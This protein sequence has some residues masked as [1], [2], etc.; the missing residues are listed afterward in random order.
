MNEI[1]GTVVLGIMAVIGIPFF[2]AV[3]FTFL[4]WL[5]TA[6]TMRQERKVDRK[7]YEND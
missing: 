5:M 3:V 7:F 6:L 2:L 1:V 4:V